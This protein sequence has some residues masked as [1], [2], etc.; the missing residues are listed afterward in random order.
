M[1]VGLKLP[2]Q[3]N[4]SGGFALSDSDENDFKIIKTALMSDHNENAFQ[5]NIGLG[6]GMIFDVND[7][8]TISRLNGRIRSIF[9]Q[10]Q[11]EKRYKLLPSTIKWVQDNSAQELTL[12]FRFISLESDE[13]KTFARTFRAGE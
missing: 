8:F 4:S 2:I 12:E 1:P 13:E 9:R 11:N 10:F 7:E 6:H 3:V 5:Q